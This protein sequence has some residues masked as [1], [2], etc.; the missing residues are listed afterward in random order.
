MFCSVLLLLTHESA[1]G[2]WK[3]DEKNSRKKTKDEEGEIFEIWTD[4]R[5]EKKILRTEQKWDIS[6]QVK[7]SRTFNHPWRE[8]ECIKCTAIQ[9]RTIFQVIS[10]YADERRPFSEPFFRFRIK[11]S[12]TEQIRN[13][14]H[15]SVLE[16]FYRYFWYQFL[17]FRIF[18][19]LQPLTLLLSSAARI[20]DHVHCFQSDLQMYPTFFRTFFQNIFRI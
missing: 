18:C 19:C 6:L 2:D 5:N 1:R 12:R 11:C 20:F 17:F 8:R 9:N 16:L 3:R 15:V 10:M 4:K 13:L 7:C 14:I